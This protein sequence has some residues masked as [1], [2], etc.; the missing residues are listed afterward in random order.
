MAVPILP[1]SRF[2]AV[3]V[4]AKANY[5]LTEYRYIRTVEQVVYQTK[6]AYY[7]YLLALKMQG[8]LEDAV[9]INQNSLNIAQLRVDSG[10]SAKIDVE[11]ATATLAS[12]NVSLIQAQNGAEIAKA[13]LCMALGISVDSDISIDTSIADI[14]SVDSSVG[15]LITQAVSNRADYKAMDKQILYL[16]QNVINT[17]ANELPSL[18]AQA[19]YT[20]KLTDGYMGATGFTAGVAVNYT[21]FDS[22]YGKYATSGAKIQVEQAKS[23]QKQLELAI[24]M[25]VKQAYINLFTANSQLVAANA[26]LSASN[27]ALRIAD[28]RYRE[29]LGILLE[30]EQ[31]QLNVTSA[32]SS[33]IQA[34]INALSAY[35]ALQYALGM[36]YEE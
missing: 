13:A 26:Q 31:A 34:Q 14:P 19:S 35:A 21:L 16:E 25:D 9:K 22:G 8:V 4:G 23:A 27:E 32:Q 11:Q 2:D 6:A 20:R 10:V 18:N 28:L 7:Q 29:G 36:N 24:G 30:V 3:K 15:D 12:S 1:W 33:I 17:R 5:D